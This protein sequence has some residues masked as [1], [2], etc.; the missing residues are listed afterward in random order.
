MGFQEQED[1][2]ANH[3]LVWDREKPSVFYKALVGDC[4]RH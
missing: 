1:N 3:S 4:L 2:N